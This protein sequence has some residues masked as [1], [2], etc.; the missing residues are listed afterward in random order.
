MWRKNRQPRK[1]TTCV[2]TDL[3]RNWR[4]KWGAQPGASP[5]PCTDTFQGRCAGDTPENI[6]VS[7]L[8]N[9]LGASPKGIRSYIDWHSYGNKILTPWGWTCEPSEQPPSLPRMLEIAGGV[10]ATINATSGA[11][12]Q[13]GTGCD[14]EYYSTGNGRDHHHGAY[15]ANHS[16]TLELEPVTSRQGDS[17]CHRTKS[18]RWSRSS[19][20]VRFGC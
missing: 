4:Y 18:G 11:V 13:Y 9:R 17:C 16:W 10:A 2:G 12:Y 1:N 15:N 3:N 5:D 19:G 14:I 8:S 7:G 20:L 6:A